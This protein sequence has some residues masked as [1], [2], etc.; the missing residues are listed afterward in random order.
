MSASEVDEPKPS[1]RA[2]PDS[3]SLTAAELLAAVQAEPHELA[4]RQVYAD[5]LLERGDPR[6][7]F[8]A[9]Q[10]AEHRGELSRRGQL[11][12]RA[13]AREHK[14]A[15]LREIIA[16]LKAS[17]VV[18]ERGFL[19]KARFRRH[20]RPE[21]LELGS[22]LWATVEWLEHAPLE[23]LR[24]PVAHALRA[25]TCDEATA[26]ALLGP[27]QPM[28]RIEHLDI[29]LDYRHV[30]PAQE[31]RYSLE[32]HAGLPNLRALGL[33]SYALALERLDW[34]WTG[35]LATQLERV[36]LRIIWVQSSR[37]PTSEQLDPRLGPLLRSLR[38]SSATISTI[39]LEHCGLR[40][41]LARGSGSE[42]REIGLDAEYRFE[43]DSLRIALAD[44]VALGDV[45]LRSQIELGSDVDP[46][47]QA[48]WSA[49]V[50]A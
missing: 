30:E 36:E 4:H 35:R 33:H 8:I 10:L 40:W 1:E 14:H 29:K 24:H 50:G 2:E 3:E 6:G 43:I 5:F 27:E 25:I 46:A 37:V 47:L 31:L 45:R 16:A 26:L 49:L 28:P 38:S 9:L 22:P 20:V 18:F 48:N 39:L 34:I 32:E 42:W 19:S 41:S 21:E 7:E 44:L 23:L 17:R 12:M 15:W 11:R 13:L